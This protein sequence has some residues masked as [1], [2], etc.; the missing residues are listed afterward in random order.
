MNEVYVEEEIEGER[1]WRCT[2]CGYIY[3]GEYPPASCPK[4]K[5]GYEE[6]EEVEK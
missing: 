4:C 2:V 6:F 5:A 3:R 1:V